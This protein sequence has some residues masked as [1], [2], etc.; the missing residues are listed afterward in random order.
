[1]NIEDVFEEFD[2]D[3]DGKI[4]ET[5][6]KHTSK[7]IRISRLRHGYVAFHGKVRA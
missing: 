7:K 6:F 1:M 5:E 2:E 3:G 4:T